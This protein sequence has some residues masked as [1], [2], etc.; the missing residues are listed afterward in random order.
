MQMY[1]NGAGNT[2]VF[3][4]NA[5]TTEEA[6]AAAEA[7]LKSLRAK[8]KVDKL[9]HE[10]W[11]RLTSMIDWWDHTKNR[12]S[13]AIPLDNVAAYHYTGQIY[14]FIKKAG[15]QSEYITTTSCHGGLN[16]AIASADVVAAV[17]PFSYAIGQ[18]SDSV[19]PY[20]FK[21]NGPILEPQSNH[22]KATHPSALAFDEVVE[23]YNWLVSDDN[24]V[25][26]DLFDREI[27]KNFVVF[28]TEDGHPT[29]M[30]YEPSKYDK[31][32]GQFHAM[33]RFLSNA[34]QAHRRSQL[35]KDYRKYRQA[36]Y[37]VRVTVALCE[38]RQG[39]IADCTVIFYPG[40]KD[41]TL[42]FNWMTGISNA[43]A[44]NWSSRYIVPVTQKCQEWDYAKDNIETWAKTNNINIHQ[45][46]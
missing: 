10:D 45:N 7:D 32:L 29:G 36:G 31:A 24:P 13:L 5:V 33:I 2:M 12:F 11:C 25:L 21:A 9:D 46:T 42:M 14:R 15:S 39:T 27:I 18:F 34:I 16:A 38:A 19:V 35:L 26:K 44:E 41:K 4:R 3:F 37:N 23:Y 28:R 8:G 6:N 40:L 22:E 17:V 20:M 1:W 43:K 30:Y